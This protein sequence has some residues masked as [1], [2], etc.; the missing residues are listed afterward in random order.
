MLPVED[1]EVRPF[2][3]FKKIFALYKK[4]LPETFRLNRRCIE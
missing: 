4:D 1:R 3:F 2:T